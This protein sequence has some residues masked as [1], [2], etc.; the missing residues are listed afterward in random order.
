MTS[1]S[2][3]SPLFSYVASALDLALALATHLHRSPG[4][5]AAAAGLTDHLTADNLIVFVAPPLP[6][7]ATAGPSI[8]DVQFRLPAGWRPPSS[9]ANTDGSAAACTALGK[10]LLHVFSMGHS[11]SL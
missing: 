11:R 2:Q 10:T 6:N 7:G 5:V 8:I 1:A 3:G 9:M 4:I